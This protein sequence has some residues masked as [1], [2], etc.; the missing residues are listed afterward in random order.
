[1]FALFLSDVM[2]PFYQ[3]CSSLP[4]ILFTIALVLC[5]L[6][7]LLAVLGLVDLDFLDF[8]IPEA[9]DLNAGDSLSNLNVLS[10]VIFKLGLNGVPFMIVLSLISL[11]GWMLSFSLVFFINPWLPGFVLK[12]IGGT[13]IF[14]AS[15]YLAVMVTAQL[16]KPLRPI[17]Q[18]ANQEVQKTIV[19]K[20]GIVRSGR[21]D[22][23]FGEAVIEDGGAGLILKVR[24]YKDEIFQRGDRVV[25]LEHIS[26]ENYYRVISERDFNGD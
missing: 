26:P 23:N 8:D 9:D 1:M 5:L 11:L 10:G 3:I 24:S 7:W 13:L 16:I 21:V 20:V 18:S 22:N 6:Y 4:T 17:F 14:A 25:L 19:G 15:F 2:D 12:L